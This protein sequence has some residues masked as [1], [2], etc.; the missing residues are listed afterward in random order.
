MIGTPYLDNC[1]VDFGD[2]M[3]A[4]D[5]IGTYDEQKGLENFVNK[6]AD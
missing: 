3:P 1:L 5:A 2:I 4:N 6:I